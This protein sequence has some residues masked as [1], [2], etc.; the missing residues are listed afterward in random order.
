MP[1]TFSHPAL[2]LPLTYLP[3]RFYSLTG[4][5]I[6]SLTPDFEYFL[7]MKVQSNYSHTINGL[8]WFDVPLGFLLAYI[9]HNVVR[10]CLINNLP[11]VL[12]SRFLTYKKFAWNCNLRSKWIITLISLLIGS[13]SH[14]LW[15]GF[16]HSTGHFVQTISVLTNNI[17]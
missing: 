4:I 1:F 6:G 9:F 11:I 5:I 17:K 2:V 13:A 7:R 3:H 15:D 16:T 14:L 10:N 12:Q 8:F